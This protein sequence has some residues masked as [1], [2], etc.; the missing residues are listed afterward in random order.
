MTTQR[1]SAVDRCVERAIAAKWFPHACLLVA[2]RGQPVYH[3]AYGAARL[4]TVFDLASLTKVLATTSAMLDLVEREEIK[5]GAS[6]S[7]YLPAL[8][9]APAGRCRIDDLLF[10]CAGLAAW[11][12]FYQQRTVLAARSW[13]GRRARIRKLAAHT[14]LAYRARHS[15]EYSDLGF[16]LLDQL[17][18]TRLGASLDLWFA[19]RIAR[20][21]G[22]EGCLFAAQHRRAQSTLA[23]LSIAPTE[24]APRSRRHLLGEVHDDNTRAM[25]GVSGHAG[26]FGSAYHIHQIIAQ[27]QRAYD[28]QPALFPHRT[29]R[30]FVRAQSPDRQ[31]LRALGFDRAVRAKTISG[32]HFSRQAV[33]HLGFTGPSFWWEPERHRWVIFLC[34][35]VYRGREPNPMPR[36]RPA[37]HDAIARALTR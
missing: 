12:P 5:L 16:I 32:S 4:D 31:S 7:D 20:P 36:F 21:L 9:S 14:P 10:H 34:N 24:R 28:G 6:L 27:Y 22:L 33:G 8:A 1:F 17:L 3:R 30:R 15:S 19:E 29:L 13:R 2:D 26:L 35:R 37:L 25:G 18:E 23:K 11:Q